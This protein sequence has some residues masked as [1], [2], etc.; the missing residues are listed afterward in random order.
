MHLSKA[1]LHFIDG[2][3][4]FIAKNIVKT[5]VGLCLLMENILRYELGRKVDRYISPKAIHK[6]KIY[7]FSS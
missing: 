2:S 6:R 7:N 4:C 5:T 1:S 3:S